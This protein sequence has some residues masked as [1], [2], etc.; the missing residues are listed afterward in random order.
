MNLKAPNEIRE[1]ISREI[2]D[3]QPSNLENVFASES[4]WHTALEQVIAGPG[5][6]YAFVGRSGESGTMLWK[7]LCARERLLLTAQQI[8]LQATLMCEIDAANTGFSNMR[9]E[10]HTALEELT[11]AAAMIEP[12]L[13]ALK[14]L[15]LEALFRSE[16]RL[17]EFRQWLG[18]LRGQMEYAEGA[19]RR[20][21]YRHARG[22]P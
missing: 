13:R 10:A 1:E 21:R 2:P 8:W 18:E 17:E 15:Y 3:T 4:E 5:K 7:V 20:P 9:D 16:P 11:K 14:P 22:A 12:E 19:L 6:I